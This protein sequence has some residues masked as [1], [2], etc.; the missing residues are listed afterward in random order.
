MGDTV[1]GEILDDLVGPMGRSAQGAPPDV[2]G[3]PHVPLNLGDREGG[4][5]VYFVP[6]AGLVRDRTKVVPQGWGAGFKRS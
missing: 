1:S 6:E 2:S 4:A 5:G 3:V